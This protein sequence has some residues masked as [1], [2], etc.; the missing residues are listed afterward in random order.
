MSGD[1]KA[2]VEILLERKPEISAEEIKNLVDEKKRKIG[3]GYLTD[4]GALFLVAADLGISLERNQ[5]SL[6]KLK[7]LYVGAR[8]ISVVGRV[9]SI[10]PTR[11][12]MRRDNSEE[13]HNRTITIVDGDAA[14]RLKLWEKRV[15]FPEESG[16]RPGDLIK[17]TK[18][19][20]KSGLDGKPVL[21]IGDMSTIEVI[22]EESMDIPSLDHFARDLS[23]ISSQTD[24]VVILGKISSSPRMVEYKNIRGQDS[25]ALQLNVSNEEGTK[26][27][28]TIIWNIDESR[29]P[30]ILTVGSN[31][32]LVGVRI[33]QGNTQYGNSEFEIHGDEGTSFDVSN[34]EAE[35]EVL[36]L[37]IISV[38]K[39]LGT[40]YLECLAFQKD[41]KITTLRIDSNLLK[42]S[43]S[44][45]TIIQCIPSMILGNQITLYRDDSYVSEIEDDSSFP[46][47]EK[48]ETK[49]E[50]IV[51]SDR[52]YLVEG[53]VLQTPSINAVTTRNGENVSLAETILGDDTAEISLL[54]WRN[55]SSLVTELKVGERIKI[56]GVVTSTDR[57]G[58]LQLSL[59][60][61]SSINKIG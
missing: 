56:R 1:F 48:L 6:Q 37:K 60:P 12:F 50:D 39:D 36:A 31:I 29:L 51:N 47:L 32:R 14:I 17:L 23:Q 22:K 2:M 9:M 26:T 16:L 4:Q 58:K 53:I 21:N 20:V 57:D 45:G 34:P 55:L 46:S 59:K 35:P 44:S 43:I 54:G 15:E 52:P 41:G 18:C 42:T 24:N 19:Y 3:A 8:D 30:K 7:D 25:K 27:L 13:L 38:G 40:G 10:Y 28:R 5:S 33:K 11:T 61:Y 49:I